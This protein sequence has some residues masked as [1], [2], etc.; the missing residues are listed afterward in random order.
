LNQHQ[1]IQEGALAK[2]AAEDAKKQI[3]EAGGNNIIINYFIFHL[4]TKTYLFS[5]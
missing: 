1:K 2:D 4:R 5:I 3:E